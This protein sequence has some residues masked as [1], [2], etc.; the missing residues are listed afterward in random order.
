MSGSEPGTTAEPVV[1]YEL[2]RSAAWITLNRPAVRNALSAELVAG[3]GDGLDRA[4]R[5]PGVRSVVIAG[6]GPMFCAG[7]DLKMVLG[8]LPE[9]GSLAEFLSSVARLCERIAGQPK[10]VIAAVHG[11]VIA[12]GLELVLA[13]DLV[14]ASEDASFCDGHARY[15][16]FP[17]AGGATRLPRKIGVNRAKQL[18]FTGEFWSAERMREC[19]LVNEVVPAAELHGAV[20]AMTD[21]IGKRSP[22]GIAGMKGVVEDGLERPLNE[23]LALE[24]AECERY[25]ATSPDFTEG[26]R[27]FAERRDPEFAAE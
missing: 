21:Q 4:G 14:I 16:L 19:G 25:A 6:N 9:N 23:A 20:D 11:D 15:G 5:D 13:C 10:P 3:I 17:A 22:A 24:L 7:A 18:L 26:L 8:Q 1:R 2:R 12:G 27:A